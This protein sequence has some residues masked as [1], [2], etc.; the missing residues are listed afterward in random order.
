MN[1]DKS[2][3][4]RGWGFPPTFYNDDNGGIDMV[5]AEEDIKQSLEILMGTS[6]GERIMLPQYGSDLQRY[7]FESIS[8]S[9]I[10]FLSELIRTA[11][12]N[13]EP[14]IILNEVVID[15]SQYQDGIISIRLDYS[16]QTTNTRFNLVFPYYKVEGTDIP[17][18]YH[19]QV[20]QSL[21]KGDQ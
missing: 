5:E 12:I 14:R 16:I 4:G 20:T 7:L 11:I 6:L 19:K 8:N 18:L 17:Q 3:L 21:N 10:H 9:K 2:F 1:K 15:H 13:Y